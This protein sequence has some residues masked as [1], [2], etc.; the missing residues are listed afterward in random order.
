VQVIDSD[1]CAGADSIMV[2][3]SICASVADL[4]AEYGIKVY[5]NP[6]S[7]NF[8]IETITAIAVK[9][10][11]SDG[12]LVFSHEEFSTSLQV[13]LSDSGVYLIHFLI[14]NEAVK[15]YSLIVNK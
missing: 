6:T 14:E 8:T 3:V 13:N 1:N 4:E 11:R 15:I 10:Y 7:G 12:A 9:I 5:P 2:N